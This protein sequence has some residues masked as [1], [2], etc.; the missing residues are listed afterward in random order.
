MSR[1]LRIRS[2]AETLQADLYGELPARRAVILV[3]GRDWDGSGWREIALRFVERG[4]PALAINLRGKD[5]ST[6]TTDE[7]VEGHVHVLRFSQQGVGPLGQEFPALL[8]R[9]GRAFVRNVGAGAMAFDDEAGP[10]QF[11]VGAGHGVRIDQEL[12][13]QGADRGELFARRQPARGHQVLHLVDDLQVNRDTVVRGDMNLH[14][15]LTP[16]P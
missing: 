15:S 6:G 14:R 1:T 11:Q 4:V 12:F 2:D 3:H 13:G 5:G 10:L 16:G 8:A 7:F 9:Q